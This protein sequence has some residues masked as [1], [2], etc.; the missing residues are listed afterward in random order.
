MLGRRLPKAVSGG[1]ACLVMVASFVVSADRRLAAR[2]AACPT[3]GSCSRR[4][5][6][7]IASGD[8]VIDLTFSLDPLSAVM[9]LV[10]TGI[11]SLIHIYSTAYMHEETD[12]EF[13]RYFSYLNLFASFMLD[14]RARRQ[15]R[16]D[17]RRLGGRRPLFVPVDQFLV[18]EEVGG[19]R[20]QEGVRREQDRRLRLHPRHAPPVLQL[21]H[22][23]LPGARRDR[24]RPAGR[25][26]HVRRHLGG[27][28]A[29]LHRRDRQVGAD[30]AASRGFRTRWKGRRRCPP[31]SMPRRW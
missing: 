7:W 1:L 12:S 13:A 24:R 30:S 28:A 6:T 29:A 23:R 19:R 14:A 5:Y 21:R 16:G 20:G 2:G 26:R 10:V 9:I 11:G 25:G 27:H 17:V 3:S 15:L 4:A 31:S 8:F 18:Q 22:A